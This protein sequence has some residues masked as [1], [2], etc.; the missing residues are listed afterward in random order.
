MDFHNEQ[1]P[2]M[3]P[4]STPGVPLFGGGVPQ[5]QRTLEDGPPSPR[6]TSLAHCHPLLSLSQERYNTSFKC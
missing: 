2:S 4:G 1:I 3:S 5:D 6:P